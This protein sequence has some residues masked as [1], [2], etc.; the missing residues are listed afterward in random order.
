MGIDIAVGIVLISTFIIGYKQG[1]I[2]SI[3]SVVSYFAGFFAA[4]YFSF[5][6]ANYINAN[7]N[8]PPQWIPIIAFIL[9][10]TAVI[11]MVRFLGKLIEKIVNKILPTMINRLAG[12]ALWMFIGF[13]LLSL[14]IQLLDRA[15]VLTEHLKLA[16][17]LYKYLEESGQ[18]ISD[19]LGEAIPF[20]K[21]L[22]QTADEYFKDLANQIEI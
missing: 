5:V 12:S 10:F 17:T 7:F 1:L 20:V 19:N 14:I 15:N 6:V 9:L 13:V 22:Y 11:F 4:M 18:L 21:N 3:F 8:I 16:S 2:M